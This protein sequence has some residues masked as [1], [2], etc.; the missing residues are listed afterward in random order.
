MALLLPLSMPLSSGH[1]FINQA[2]TTSCALIKLPSQLQLL[3]KFLEKFTAIKKLQ[4]E[5][6]YNYCGR[7]GIQSDLKWM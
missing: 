2:H 5:F 1:F 4:L 3:P 6:L 7:R